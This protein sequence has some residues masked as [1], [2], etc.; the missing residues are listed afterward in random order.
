M[1]AYM[2]EPGWDGPET[3]TLYT[4]E[5]RLGSKDATFEDVAPGNDI[6]KGDTK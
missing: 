1:G 4:D 6:V 5:Y 2:G 3:R